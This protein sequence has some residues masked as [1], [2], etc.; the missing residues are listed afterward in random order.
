MDQSESGLLVGPVKGRAGADWSSQFVTLTE[1]GP[2][3]GAHTPPS[4][5][6]PPKPQPQKK[7]QINCAWYDAIC[8]AKQA[9]EATKKVASDAW[10]YC[11]SSDVC[12]TVAPIVV[13][14]AVGVACT[15]ATGGAGVVGC[16]VLAGAVSGALS[17]ALGCKSG[18][19]IGGCIATGAAVGAVTGLAGYGVGK[20]LSVAGKAAV[21]ALGRTGFGQALGKAVSSG[22]S[23]ALSAVRAGASRALSAVQSGASKALGAVRAGASRAMGAVREGASRA[24]SAVRAGATRAVSAVRSAASKLFG[25]REELSEEDR[26]L[27]TALDNGR[28]NGNAP[29]GHLNGAMAEE[30]GWQRALSN[31]EVGIQGP[32][33]VTSNGPDFLTYD[34]A[35]GRINVWDSKFSSSGRF[36]SGIS[37]SKMSSWNQDIA[38]AVR[39]Y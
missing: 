28:V 37:A 36:P 30:I 18:E 2:N 32:T 14:I 3:L 8:K 17:G 29:A 9:W 23:R 16:A 26:A 11:K 31:G 6:A 5:P 19:S 25:P 12:K 27:Q 20:L 15:A 35:R 38:T 39:N 4:S 22:G 33:S 34:P 7:Q 10:N 24:I 1:V 21:G 13:S